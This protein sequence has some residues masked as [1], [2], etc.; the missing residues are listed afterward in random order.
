VHPL[1]HLHY[2]TAV[3]ESDLKK[4]VVFFGFEDVLVPG[5]VEKNIDSKKVTEILTNLQELKKSVPAFHFYLMTGHRQEQAEKKLK[6]F[7]LD[8]F[9]K[10]ENTLFVTDD[11][12]EDKAKVDRERY[13]ENLAK[14]PKFKDEYFKQVT[15]NEL[16]KELGVSEEEMVLICHELVSEAFYTMRFSKIDFAVIESAQSYL[17][18]KFDEK[19]KGLT[20]IKREWPDIKKILLGEK[21]KPDLTAFEKLIF[22]KLKESLMDTQSIK[23]IGKPL[24]GLGGGPST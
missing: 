12:V 18:K 8:K 3:N 20:Y 15:I 9:F 13:A 10:K 6:E 11:Y 24:P 4:K 5:K 1:H 21:G 17:N 2:L 14:D 7:G 22:K 16:K 23:V 19:I